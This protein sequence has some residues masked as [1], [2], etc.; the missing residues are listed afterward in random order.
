MG[1]PKG[2]TPSLPSLP[3]C[4]QH[5]A[6]PQN[7]KVH[8]HKNN[9]SLLLL[10]CQQAQNDLFFAPLLPVQIGRKIREANISIFGNDSLM[11][12]CRA[13]LQYSDTLAEAVFIS[14]DCRN[15]S[16]RDYRP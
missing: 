3:F 10:F 4:S 15:K 2:S 13:F 16:K 8:M 1:E 9:I 6:L 12:L 11:R 7:I 14:R 5:S